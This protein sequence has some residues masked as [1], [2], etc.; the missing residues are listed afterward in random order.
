MDAEAKNEDGIYVYKI[1]LCSIQQVFLQCQLCHKKVHYHFDGIP[2][3]QVLH[4]LF[5][6][7]DPA[8]LH[9]EVFVGC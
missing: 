4:I 1:V 6:A 9:F 7:R 5:F 8:G 2:L 3:F